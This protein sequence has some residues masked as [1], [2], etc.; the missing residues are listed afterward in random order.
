MTN[1]QHPS[2]AL[3]DR[4]V[5]VH[6]DSIQFTQLTAVS[7]HS[8][9]DNDMHDSSFESVSSNQNKPKRGR[10]KKCNL[11]QRESSPLNAKS[12]SNGKR[13]T[14]SS[15]TKQTPTLDTWLSGDPKCSVPSQKQNQT[16][17]SLSQ[18]SASSSAGGSAPDSV[19]F[20]EDTL[21]FSPRKGCE[22][23]HSKQVHPPLR[24]QD[25]QDIPETPPKDSQ[26]VSSQSLLTSKH[27]LPIN[28]CE[29]E[30]MQSCIVVAENLKPA[31]VEQLN[32]PANSFEEHA[33]DAVESLQITTNCMSLSEATAAVENL[34]NHRR[35]KQ[36]KPKPLKRLGR[37]GNATRSETT[38]IDSNLPKQMRGKSMSIN[39]AHLTTRVRLSEIAIPVAPE[40][41]K[42]VINKKKK[43]KATSQLPP[44][45]PANLCLIA[46]P[47]T[48][49]DLVPVSNAIKVFEN[50]SFSDDNN[51]LGKAET[52][53]QPVTKKDG[54]SSQ[55]VCNG[56]NLPET[57][58]ALSSIMEQGDEII[59]ANLQV[60]G[61]IPF[62]SDAGNDK[63]IMRSNAAV[64]YVVDANGENLLSN[65]ISNQNSKFI[66]ESKVDVAVEQTLGVAVAPPVEQTSG[67]KENCKYPDFNQPPISSSSIFTEVPL[68]KSIGASEN[69]QTSSSADKMANSVTCQRESVEK[70]AEQEILQSNDKALQNDCTS[71]PREINEAVETENIAS[72]NN[73]QSL[74]CDPFSSPSVKHLRKNSGE[75]NKDEN[76]AAAAFQFSSPDASAAKKELLTT[77]E[78][79][80]SA[81][82]MRLCMSRAHRIVQYGIMQNARDNS[83]LWMIPSGSF[84]AVTHTVPKKGIL[85]NSPISGG[86]P[87]SPSYLSPRLSL[88]RSAS[89]DQL[90]PESLMKVKF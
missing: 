46:S 47:K 88:K 43:C 39:K 19:S 78:T 10:P 21:Q 81:Q 2:L 51:I 6:V 74:C 84:Q 50:S 24:S 60:Q 63:C 69:S 62:D 17:L 52:S 13:S 16:G 44:D 31:F 28:H 15:I 59:I 77:P 26:L 55:E 48:N 23:Q 25:L 37:R 76:V 49:A 67:M 27:V 1:L 87:T 70:F 72:V 75:E 86:S 68:Y 40:E 53:V 71:D 12:P 14:R 80:Q 79:P 41:V 42:K 65:L 9:R 61:T 73:L 83:A 38:V 22:V 11:D 7:P 5:M 57:A 8:E 64:Q 66:Q 30:H 45:Q 58:T 34:I 3:S 82:R 56:T 54:G 90:S 36:S 32:K 33:Q 35:R 18:D 4:Q 29:A 20:V 85:K 89:G